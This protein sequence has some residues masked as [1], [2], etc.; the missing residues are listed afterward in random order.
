VAGD[1]R[2]STVMRFHAGDSPENPVTDLTGSLIMS[3]FNFFGR[4]Q[5]VKPLMEKS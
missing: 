3:I 2:G 4:P 5:S 1:N